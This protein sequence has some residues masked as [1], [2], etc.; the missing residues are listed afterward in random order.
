LG[1]SVHERHR[2][3]ERRRH[4]I[5]TRCQGDLGHEAIV[6]RPHHGL[7]EVILSITQFGLQPR[8]LSVD[9]AYL[10][11]RGE[12]RT[13]LIGLGAR[14]GLFRRFKITR[15]CVQ[16]CFGMTFFEKSSASRS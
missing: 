3:P 7:I 13:L 15:K 9:P 16:R 14:I 11:R 10:R 8:H 6:W 2:G 12:L 5:D 1:V 4:H